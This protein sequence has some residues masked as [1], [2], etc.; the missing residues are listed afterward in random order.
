MSPRAGLDRGTI[1]AAAAELTDE[2]G[3]E[4]VTLALLARKLNVKSPSLYNHMNGLPELKEQLTLLGLERLNMQLE[5]GI[6]EKS[7]KEG[8]LKAA[9]AYLTFADQHPGLYTLIQRSPSGDST[10]LQA[11]SGEVVDRM[12]AVLE[13]YQLDEASRIHAVR[14]FRS[15]LHGFASIKQGGGFGMPIAIDDSL[16]FALECFFLGLEQKKKPLQ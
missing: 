9:N 5:Q 12:I 13:P 4:E 14:G 8:V 3:F 2:L 10:R 15:L 7:G 1:V 11:L 16:S 6:G